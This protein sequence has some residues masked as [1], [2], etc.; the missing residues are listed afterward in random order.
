MKEKP[1]V[2]NSSKL[3]RAGQPAS[4]ACIDLSEMMA[5]QRLSCLRI[6]NWSAF[7]FPPSRNPS[8]HEKL[9]TR[10][11]GAK[12]CTYNDSGGGGIPTY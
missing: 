1:Q 9:A 4:K 10:R 2:A 11:V 12:R 8:Q 7:A 6:D 5:L 3:S